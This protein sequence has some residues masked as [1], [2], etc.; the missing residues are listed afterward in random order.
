MIVEKA[1]NSGI[2]T[3]YNKKLVFPDRRNK[4]NPQPGEDWEI[5]ITGQNPAGT[6]YFASF[7]KRNE[8]KRI[9]PGSF[10]DTNVIKTYYKEQISSGDKVI[11]E[12]T[13]TLPKGYKVNFNT[14]MPGS[15]ASFDIT[16]D[17][18][19]VVFLRI[20]LPSTFQDNRAVDVSDEMSDRLFGFGVGMDAIDSALVYYRR[21]LE[22]RRRS[23][24]DEDFKTSQ[25]KSKIQEFC[26]LQIPDIKEKSLVAERYELQFS[27]DEDW[28]MHKADPG[29][30][31]TGIT[32]WAQGFELPAK[33]P[34]SEIESRF[35]RELDVDLFEYLEACEELS[36][37]DE[38]RVAFERYRKFHLHSDYIK[39]NISLTESQ[40]SEVDS[41]LSAEKISGRPSYALYGWF[42]K[43]D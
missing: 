20:S 35:A 6:V 2:M 8:K 34:I 32:M 10:E 4:T 33:S 16:V 12:K 39:I 14:M 41:F 38:M 42:K 1:K 18:E 43:P 37:D 3:R 30:F 5:D 13:T 11:Y 28:G 7:V 29:V 9:I 31:L 15:W 19:V 40:V 26:N 22:S 17:G 36:R 24:D 27:S 23:D 25:F 21:W